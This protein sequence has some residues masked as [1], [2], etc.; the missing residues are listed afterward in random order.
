LLPWITRAAVADTGSRIPGHP[1]NTD[2]EEAPE[3]NLA[4]EMGHIGNDDKFPAAS[5]S[6]TRLTVRS[7]GTKAAMAAVEVRER[8]Q[9]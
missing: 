7:P 5:E 3:G 8:R 9:G 4:D 1:A 2:E 6:L